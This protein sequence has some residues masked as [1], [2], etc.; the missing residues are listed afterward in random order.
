MRE[1]EIEPNQWVVPF[2]GGVAVGLGRAV[3]DRNLN[4]DASNPRA[5]RGASP[6]LAHG[7]R[8]YGLTLR[9]TPKGPVHAAV[10]ADA[11]T[12]KIITR[13]NGPFTIGALGERLSAPGED[14]CD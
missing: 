3:Y 8:L 13:H 14:G 6:P 9:C 12:G 11:L 2:R 4:L 1:I 5:L 7:R 10:A